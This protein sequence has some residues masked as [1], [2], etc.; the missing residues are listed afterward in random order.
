MGKYIKPKRSSQRGE[1][2]VVSGISYK[3]CSKTD[4]SKSRQLQPLTQFRISATGAGGR[5]S[6]C[7]TCR[8]KANRARYA[9]KPKS[10]KRAV[11]QMIDG[12]QHKRCVGSV[13]GGLILPLTHFDGQKDGLGGRESQCKQCTSQRHK[14]N[15]A[16]LTGFM[17]NMANRVK[18]CDDAYRAKGID[19]E[20]ET[21]TFEQLMTKWKAQIGKCA[22]TGLA[23]N[24]KSFTDWQ[25]S[26]ERIDNNKIHSNANTILIV[27][28]MNTRNQV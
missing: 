15:S 28:E 25:C 9:L 26:P 2:E 7:F 1:V 6:I 16:T 4:C 3:R 23:M 5:R 20:N 18:R 14:L 11:L 19:T 8:N 17:T 27:L 24:H 22:I 12:V 10:G 21:V 13:C